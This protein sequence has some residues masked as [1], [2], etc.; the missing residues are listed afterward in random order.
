[1]RRTTGG[2]YFDL[3]AILTLAFTAFLLVSLPGGCWDDSDE[4][5]E[6]REDTANTEA[7]A[8]PTE[9]EMMEI[10]EPDPGDIDTGPDQGEGEDAPEALEGENEPQGETGDTPDEEAENDESQDGTSDGTYVVQEGDTL[11]DIAIQMGVSMDQLMEANDMSDPNQL[12]V[13]QELQAP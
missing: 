9:S 1:M 4:D 7:T 6:D 2:R 8:E 3:S 10:V 11:Y 5:G 13:G 12:Q